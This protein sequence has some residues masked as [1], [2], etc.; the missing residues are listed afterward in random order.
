MSGHGAIECPRTEERLI[1]LMK[2]ISIVKLDSGSRKLKVSKE[3]T[4]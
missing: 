1:Y 2:I 4:H 3:F